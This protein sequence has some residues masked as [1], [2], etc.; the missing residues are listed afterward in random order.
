MI[1][2]LIS[3]SPDYKFHDLRIRIKLK[4]DLG[5]FRFIHFMH[6]LPV[7]AQ[8]L[9]NENHL[10]CIFQGKKEKEKGRREHRLQWPIEITRVCF[11]IVS[12]ETERKRWE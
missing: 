12:E 5:S 11:K 8:G 2:C 1:V 9:V 4:L 6:P 10:I 3:D 7:P